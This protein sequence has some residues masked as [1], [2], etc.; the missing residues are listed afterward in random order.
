M[1]FLY[2]YRYI[3]ANTE[4]ARET[5]KY[6]EKAC[7]T[8]IYMYHMKYISVSKIDSVMY[9]VVLIVSSLYTIRYVRN[10]IYMFYVKWYI[11]DQ[12]I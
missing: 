5:L 4:A 8:S 12:T 11:F 6:I 7:N 1:T 10:F 9:I 2:R 3:S